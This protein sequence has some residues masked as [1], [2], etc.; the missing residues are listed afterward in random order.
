METPKTA[1]VIWCY[2]I[3]YEEQLAKNLAL[4][5]LGTAARQLHVLQRQQASALL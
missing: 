3:I 4:A 1:G 2:M 5:P